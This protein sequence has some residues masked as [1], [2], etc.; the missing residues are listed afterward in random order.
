MLRVYSVICR[1]LILFL[2]LTVVSAAAN[3]ETYGNA[4]VSEVT[5]IY[6][7]DTFRANIAGWPDIIGKRIPIRVKGIDAPELRGKCKKEIE[8]ARQAKQETVSMIRAA[9]QI[10][11]RNMERDKYFRILADVYLDG[12]SLGQELMKKGLARSYDG[13][14]KSIWCP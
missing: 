10:E 7:A 11:L 9:K 4:I 8:S 12:V 1:S 6:N 13:G 14:N 2:A 3:S 5:S